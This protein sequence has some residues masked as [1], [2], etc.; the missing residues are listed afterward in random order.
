MKIHRNNFVPVR[1]RVKKP[2][3]KKKG[4][5]TIT[6]HLSRPEEIK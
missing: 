3:P 5:G 6:H 2:P 4:G 1:R